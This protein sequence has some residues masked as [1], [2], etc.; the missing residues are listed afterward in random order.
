MVLKR[1]F[2]LRTISIGTHRLTYQKILYNLKNGDKNAIAWTCY[3]HSMESFW[4][5]TLH[6]FFLINRCLISGDETVLEGKSHKDHTLISRAIAGRLGPFTQHSS[7]RCH[8]PNP[9]PERSA[10]AAKV[11]VL[12]S[13]IS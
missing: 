5:I 13:G 8:S 1:C 4:A 2:N 12:I 7:W 3:D 10:S 6:S 9:P 11:A